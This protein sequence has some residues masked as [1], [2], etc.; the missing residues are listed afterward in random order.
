[1]NTVVLTFVLFASVYGGHVENVDIDWS[2]VRPIKYY[3]NFWDD[4]PAE[5]RPPV[6]FFHKYQNGMN[7]IVGG[8]IAQ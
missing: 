6:K 2:T 4:K 3:P 7:R 8:R 1:M 5:F